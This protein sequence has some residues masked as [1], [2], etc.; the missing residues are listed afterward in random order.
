MS[1]D[2]GA[3]VPVHTNESGRVGG[4]DVVDEWNEQADEAHALIARMYEDA[5][6]RIK[7]MHEVFWEAISRP[8]T[9]FGCGSTYGKHD[10]ARVHRSTPC[11]SSGALDAGASAVDTHV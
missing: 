7:D 8:P 5:L 10:P 9:P 3:R 6:S 2:G 11:C 1:D 4:G